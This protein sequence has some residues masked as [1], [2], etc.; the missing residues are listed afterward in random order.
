MAGDRLTGFL[1]YYV[2]V[3]WGRERR[4]GARIYAGGTTPGRGVN[5]KILWRNRSHLRSRWLLLE[6]RRLDGE[7]TFRQG[8]R[9]Y[10]DFPSIVEI[11]TAGCWRLD[12]RNGTGRYSLT[13]LAI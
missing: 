5:M 12:I 8:F 7:G 13:F 11:P 9:G 4:P 6:G 1:F 3:P 2:S 10:G